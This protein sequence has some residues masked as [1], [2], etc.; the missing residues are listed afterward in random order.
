MAEKL[1][2]VIDA[3]DQ[4]SPVLKGIA[5]T[6]KTSFASMAGPIKA[7]AGEIRAAGMATTAFG[8]ATLAV[9]KGNID[10]YR[11]QEVSH[12]KL[13][14]AIKG[15]AQSIDQSR[16][17]KLAADLQK[18]TTFGD[19]A[20]IEMMALLTT[21]NL[22]QDQIESLTPRIQ[23]IS[24]IMGTDMQ[25]AAIAVGKAISTANWGALTRFGI[26][27]DE[28]TQ[29]SGDFVE[30]MKAIDRNTGPAAE[31]LA[32]GA[33][34][35]EQLA[36][37]F[38]D[39][40]EVAGEA[41]IPVLKAGVAVLKP[42]VAVAKA[43]VDT[44][45]GKAFIIAATGAGLLAVPL[46]AMIMMLP[47]A[48]KAWEILTAAQLRNAAAANTVAAANTRA[49]AAAVAG[50]AGAAAGGAASVAGGAAVGAGAG[51][52]AGAIVGRLG[53]YGA[54]A[55]VAAGGAQYYYSKKQAT[56][57][58]Q[59]ADIE[60]GATETPEQKAL[61]GANMAR[62][63]KA[64][65]QYEQKSAAGIIPGAAE[66]TSAGIIP[67]AEAMPSLAA[68]PSEQMIS[69][70]LTAAAQDPLLSTAA[71]DMATGVARE[72][73]AAF[74]EAMPEAVSSIA[75]QFAQGVAPDI[76]KAQMKKMLAS[77]ALDVAQMD[78]REQL[79][80]GWL[81]P[82]EQAEARTRQ[83]PRKGAG[84]IT[85]LGDGRFSLPASAP[86]ASIARMRDLR[87]EQDAEWEQRQ[88][89][90]TALD[91]WYERSGR[92][93]V[94]RKTGK[95]IPTSIEDQ[96][97]E[98]MRS[99]PVAINAEGV[100]VTEQPLPGGGRKLLFEVTIPRDD[101]PQGVL[102]DNTDAYLED[103]GYQGVG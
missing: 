37:E 92:R 57:E 24:A 20:T 60:S 11:T 9:A 10:A 89:E 43:M 53:L 39:L 40:R 85:D 63:Q 52:G 16:L 64:R 46:G 93:D 87:S 101:L 34:A 21:F 95:A 50:G 4:A 8:I 12:A 18:V 35:A 26:I 59:I 5:G 2:I 36:N 103:Y 77:G 31:E 13:S 90:Q 15:T 79:V 47:T 41:L 54:A 33:G 75:E 29:K 68:V 7:H 91:A 23:N 74:A 69:D 14:A 73:V 32:K 80:F 58:A 1:Q 3:K 17:E 94:V 30:I 44:P 62:W 72:T 98:R 6:A 67:G 45:L 25:S 42:M 84:G 49:G 99:L 65:G 76:L 55:M 48:V 19:E 56:A 102:T 86:S 82:K 28:D 70:E 22:T 78:S 61:L 96:A 97:A 51:L 38:G 66:P 100:T 83:Y 71:Q 27:I 88:A 81:P